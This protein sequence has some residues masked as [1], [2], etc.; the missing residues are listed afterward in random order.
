SAAGSGRAGCGTATGEAAVRSAGR[1]R[2]GRTCGSSS[3]SGCGAPGARPAGGSR[4]ARRLRAATD[5]AASTFAR[6]AAARRADLRGGRAV[7][8]PELRITPARI[9]A[10]V[11]TEVIMAAGICDSKG[12]YVPRQPLEWMLAQDGVGQIVAVGHES[13]GD[14]SYLLRNS[15]QKVATNYAR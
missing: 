9:V 4:A 10:P 3:A 2:S 11:N 8:G 7:R 6:K 1:R 15:P 14:T 13:L 5:A 12:Y